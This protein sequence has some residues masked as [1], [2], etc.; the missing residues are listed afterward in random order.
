M[1]LKSAYNF[2]TILYAKKPD[3]VPENWRMIMDHIGLEAT[4]ENPFSRAIY[5]T[6]GK[7]VIEFSSKEPIN[8]EFM[9][10]I[11]SNSRDGYDKLGFGLL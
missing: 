11:S 6:G 10:C 8:K 5:S 9:I 3:K 4:E 2:W 7:T 1:F